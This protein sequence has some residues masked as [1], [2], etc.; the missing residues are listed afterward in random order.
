MS[1][2]LDAKKEG[3]Q[4]TAGEVIEFIITNKQGKTIS[5]KS[6]FA[7]FVS[8]G[9]YD[10]DYYINNQLIPA[11]YPILEVFGVTSDELLTGKKQKGLGDYL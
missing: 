9:D 2:L 4:I 5:E 1:A 11:I 3:K 8:E 6:R 10:I 7:E